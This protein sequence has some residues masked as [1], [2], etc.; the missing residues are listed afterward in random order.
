MT[1][2][3]DIDRRL[4][5]LE[6]HAG[7][8]GPVLMPVWVK[9]HESLRQA[10]E[11]AVPSGYEVFLAIIAPETSATA[12]DWLREVREDGCFDSPDERRERH[13]RYIQ[14]IDPVWEGAHPRD[15]ATINEILARKRSEPPR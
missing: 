15:P 11:R 13:E 12:D 3:Q 5:S 6:H 7:L 1:S 14:A 8:R 4:G 2:R 9:R 10:L